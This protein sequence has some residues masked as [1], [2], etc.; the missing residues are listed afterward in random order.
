MY[1]SNDKKNEQLRLDEK[2]NVEDP[3]LDQLKLNIYEIY[4]N[5]LEQFSKFFRVVEISF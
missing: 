3:F 4:R 2:T 5:A 1:L